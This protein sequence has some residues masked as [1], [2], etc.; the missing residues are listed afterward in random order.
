MRKTLGCGMV[1]TLLVGIS[2]AAGEKPPADFQQAMKDSGAA[3]QKIA[4]DAEAKDFGA[5]A[6]SAANLK[7]GFAGP[8]GKYWTEKK[9]EAGLRKC[10]EAHAAADVLEKAAIAKN[11][12]QVAD[13]RKVLQA[14]CGSCHTAHREQLPDKTYEIKL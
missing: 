3:M 14:T 13:A 1:L 10:S 5:I 12:M 8:I 11:E 2:V 9:N 4:K 7:K 6:A